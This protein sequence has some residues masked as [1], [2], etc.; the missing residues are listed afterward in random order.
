MKTKEEIAQVLKTIE[1]TTAFAKAE[2]PTTSE[3]RDISTYQR[4][5]AM[6]AETA[7]TNQAAYVG[8]VESH[9]GAIILKG[10][11]TKQAI[12]ADRAQKIGNT[13]VFDTNAFYEKLTEN[14]FFMMGGTGNL[15]VDQVALVFTELRL[16]SRNELDMKRMREPDFQW[17]FMHSWQTNE[18]FAEGIRKSIFGTNGIDLTLKAL[19]RHAGTESLNNPTP[20]TTVPIVLIGIKDAEDELFHQAFSH[21]YIV[22]DVDAVEATDEVVTQTFIELRDIIKTRTTP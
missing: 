3:F 22:V 7:S 5:K 19:L 6:A 14:A 2:I 21:G 17:M 13:L 10:D 15:G 18:M 1:E 11:R 9:L 12:F 20:R 4:M 16:K 8:F